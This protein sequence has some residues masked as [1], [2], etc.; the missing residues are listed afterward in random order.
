MRQWELAAPGGGSGKASFAIGANYSIDEGVIEARARLHTPLVNVRLLPQPELCF[1]RLLSIGGSGIALDA[2][3]DLPLSVVGWVDS[4]LRLRL[5]STGGRGIHLTQD[6]LELDEQAIKLGEA[7]AAGV[8]SASTL[9][10]SAAMQV[11]REWPIKDEQPL[12]RLSLNRLALRV[13]IDK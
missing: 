13:V 2:R 1:R 12:I 6:G 9:R 3:Y 8:K 11:P 4:R 5:V 7:T 10:V